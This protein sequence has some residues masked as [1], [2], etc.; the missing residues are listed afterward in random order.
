MT[1]SFYSH[2]RLLAPTKMQLMA[3]STL[4]WPLLLLPSAFAGI[5]CDGSTECGLTG[6]SLSALLSDVGRIDDGRYY[7]NGDHIACQV[8]HDGSGGICAFLKNT[9][10]APGSSI[11]PLLQALEN[12]GC[13]RCGSV[14]LYYPQGDNND[15]DHGVLTVNFVSGLDGC[16][17]LC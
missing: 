13:S 16:S 1:D 17:G 4:L 14:P 12:H 15:G 8:A 2:N 10:G 5:N 7:N 3:I 6:D 9:G 11:E